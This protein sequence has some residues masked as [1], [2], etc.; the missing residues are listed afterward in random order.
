[1]YYQLPP[2]VPAKPQSR[3]L[4]QYLTRGNLFLVVAS[5]CIFALL[6][7]NQA[8]DAVA[9][10]VILK[11]NGSQ[12]VQEDAQRDAEQI[13]VL[14]L[15]NFIRSRWDVPMRQAIDLVVK[16]FTAGKEQAI[17]PL[18]I[19][20][21]MA[22]ESSFVHEGNAH[23]WLRGRIGAVDPLRAHGLMQIAGKWHEEKMP[24]DASGQLRETTADENVLIGAKILSEYLQREGGDLPAALQR[25]NGNLADE[26]RRFARAVLA[27]KRDMEAAVPNT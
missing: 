12:R 3:L 18:L 4:S 7:L 1:M 14:A 13:K 17:D 15:A 26:T 23:D 5:T 16:A 21:V 24:R 2:P 19:L 27:K 8:S 6:C 10:E 25:Y 20:A 9:N 22:Q 11:N